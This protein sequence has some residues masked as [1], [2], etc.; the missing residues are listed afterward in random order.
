MKAVIANEVFAA[1]NTE[2]TALIRLCD[3]GLE[4]R[5]RIQAEN[6]TEPRF[7][8]WMQELPRPLREACRVAFD[9]GL[10]AEAREPSRFVI[11]VVAEPLS[12]WTARPP[13]LMLRD[14]LAFLTTT[15]SLLV[16]D[17]VSDRAFL[18]AMA[19]PEQRRWLEEREKNGWLRFENG[20]GVRAMR[21]P[22]LGYKEE[23]LAEARVFVLFDSDA[24]RPGV[25]GADSEALWAS[26]EEPPR[27]ERHRL[28]RR[29]SEN[30]LPREVLKKHVEKPHPQ[31]EARKTLFLAF[32]GL[33][34]DQRFHFNMKKGLRGDARNTEADAGDLYS[35]LSTEDK[36]AL[37]K[38]FGS[39][40]G[41]LF[42]IV[43]IDEHLLQSD[44]GWAEMNPIVCS[45][46][47]MLR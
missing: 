18:L 28:R 5:H 3:V 4:G 13:R 42:G 47:A 19:T 30:Y 2:P 33:R 39:D 24:L 46:I 22:V 15:F 9:A 21:R 27:L 20:G 41:K 8:Q 32:D 26:C 35:A 25:P 37:E 38:G 7:Q 16:E 10:E 14:A 45:I 12:D 6:E 17:H 23:P 11:H 44:G 40:I 36:K 34:D 31:R 29:A 43:P 1:A